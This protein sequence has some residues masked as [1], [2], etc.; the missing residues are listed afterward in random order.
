[1]SPP[2]A[3]GAFGMST[4]SDPHIV[5]TSISVTAKSLVPTYV[6]IHKI[7]AADALNCIYSVWLARCLNCVKHIPQANRIKISTFV[8]LALSTSLKLH[9]H[10]LHRGLVFLQRTTGPDSVLARLPLVPMQMHTHKRRRMI[11]AVARF[12]VENGMGLAHLGVLHL[13]R[14]CNR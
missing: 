13:L 9:C 11:S 8:S 2:K 12:R 5:T 6:L 10:N 14:Y 1:M 3:E 7:N 4:T